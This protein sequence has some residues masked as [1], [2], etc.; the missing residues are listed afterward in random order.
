[1]VPGDEASGDRQV[2]VISYDLWRRRFDSDAGQIGRTVMLDGRA[3]AL[4]GVAAENFKGTKL[5]PARPDFWMPLAQSES[6]SPEERGNRGLEIVG[7]LRDGVTVE[8]A[9]TQISAVAARLARE[10]PETNLGTLAQPNEPRPATVTPETR[11][12]PQ[13]QKV[14]WTR[15]EP[16]ACVVGGLLLIACANVANL[17]LARASARRRE[18]AIRLSLGAGRLRLVRQLL[19]ESFCLAAIGGAA[20][21]LIAVWSADLLP[22]L[23]PGGDAIPLDFTVDW[24]VLGFTALLSCLSQALFGLAPALQATRLEVLPA[25]EGQSSCRLR[26]QQRLN[27]RN[28]LVIAQ[29][30]LSLRAADRCGTFPPQPAQRGH[31]GPRLRHSQRANRAPRSARRRRKTGEGTSVLPAAGGAHGRSARCAF[32]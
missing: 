24:R 2:V 17:L 25:F 32:R 14:V 21:L 19:T 12:G 7:R 31:C 6:A 28:A 13:R 11:L 18:I 20:G 27:L 30:A 5:G 10:Y 23:F 9:Q 3:Y 15:R 29:V 22:A 1:L 16:D 26:R 8:E 4:V